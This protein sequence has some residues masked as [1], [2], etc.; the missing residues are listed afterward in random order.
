MLLILLKKYLYIMFIEVSRYLYILYLT[1]EEFAVIKK[2]FHL[3]ARARFRITNTCANRI[4]RDVIVTTSCEQMCQPY[5]IN[6]ATITLH[7]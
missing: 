4:P 5:S 6:L 2:N 7:Y 3:V 1:V